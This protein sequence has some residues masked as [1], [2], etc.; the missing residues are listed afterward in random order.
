MKFRS[1]TA[2]NVQV[3][4]NG[5]FVYVGDEYETTDRAEVA[6]LSAHPDVEKVTVKKDK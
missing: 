6:I 5:R 2:G 4:V 3:F 1:K